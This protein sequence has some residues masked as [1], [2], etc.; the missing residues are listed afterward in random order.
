MVMNLVDQYR[1]YVH[2]ELDGLPTAKTFECKS[3]GEVEY[4]TGH[5]WAGDYWSRDDVVSVHAQVYC[6]THGW[7]HANMGMCA[8]CYERLVNQPA[9]EMIVLQRSI[10]G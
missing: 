2:L 6:A 8:R 7:S 1:V 5:I 9:A 10:Q 3:F 4:I